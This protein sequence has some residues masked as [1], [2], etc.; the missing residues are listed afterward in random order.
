M[1]THLRFVLSAA[2]ESVFLWRDFGECW[3]C[4]GC[5]EWLG[6]IGERLTWFFGEFWDGQCSFLT[7]DTVESMFRQPQTR[8]MG[9]RRGDCWPNHP[10]FGTPT[11]FSLIRPVSVSGTPN[12]APHAPAQVKQMRHLFARADGG[13]R[14]VAHRDGTYLQSMGLGRWRR[15]CLDTMGFS[16]ACTSWRA[17]NYAIEQGEKSGVMIGDFFPADWMEAASGK[18]LFCRYESRPMV[19]HL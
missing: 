1:L 18:V 15:R 5:F 3:L 13:G 11:F 9:C 10:I 19:D 8:S 7:G 6:E 2:V 17:C 16:T 14:T 4:C 12:D